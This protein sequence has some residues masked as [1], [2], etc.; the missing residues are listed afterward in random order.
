MSMKFQNEV[1]PF[2]EIERQ[3]KGHGILKLALIKAASFL[4]TWIIN[5]ALRERLQ[6]VL[7]VAGI[8]IFHGFVW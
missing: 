3:N 1:S 7:G 4:C 6:T 5:S 8:G 2:P